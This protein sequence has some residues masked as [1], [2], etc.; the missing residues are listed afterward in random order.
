MPVEIVVVMKRPKHFQ[1]CLVKMKAEGS[2]PGSD[3][4]YTSF[5]IIWGFLL[6]LVIGVEDKD[7]IHFPIISKGLRDA[8]R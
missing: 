7:V 5:N 3:V 6:L 2:H 8:G 1:L 4:L